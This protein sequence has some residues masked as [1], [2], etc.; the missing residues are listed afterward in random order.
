S[1]P[2]MPPQRAAITRIDE[3]D[4]LVTVNG[5]TIQ[6]A[7]KCFKLFMSIVKGGGARVKLSPEAHQDLCRLPPALK[8]LI[9]S[10]AGKGGGRSI[11]PRHIAPDVNGGAKP[12]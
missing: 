2:T 5:E 3:R 7:A 4:R 12:P 10:Q 8:S 6:I 9:K 11:D 1:V